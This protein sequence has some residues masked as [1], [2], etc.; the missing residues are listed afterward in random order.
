MST[1]KLKDAL[2][3]ELLKVHRCI[4]AYLRA[5]LDKDLAI[6]WDD[7]ALCKRVVVNKVSTTRKPHNVDVPKPKTYNRLRS[8]NHEVDN[9]L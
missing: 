1:A 3:H 2:K 4:F 8:A 5:Y 7:M 9:F 6:I